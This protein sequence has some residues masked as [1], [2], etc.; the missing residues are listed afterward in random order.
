MYGTVMTMYMCFWIINLNHV[1]L[2]RV[3]LTKLWVLV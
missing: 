1:T 2:T 3:T